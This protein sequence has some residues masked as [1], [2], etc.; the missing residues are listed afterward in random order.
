MTKSW[1]SIRWPSKDGP[2]RWE[3]SPFQS[4]MKTFW[5]LLR[6]QN[7]WAKVMK[8]E[9]RYAKM[10]RKTENNN[11]KFSILEKIQTLKRD[12]SSRSKDLITRKESGKSLLLIAIISRNIRIELA[13]TPSSK[14]RL[15]TDAPLTPT[16]NTRTNAPSWLRVSIRNSKA[17]SIRDGSHFISKLLVCSVPN[18]LRKYN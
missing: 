10:A 3:F 17:T 1:I 6:R 8:F 2:V 5:K 16:A 4:K 13:R 11:E 18:L 7:A 15:P 12:F 14:S 9:N